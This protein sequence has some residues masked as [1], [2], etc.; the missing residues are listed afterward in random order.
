MP[1]RSLPHRQLRRSRKGSTYSCDRFTAAQ[2]A[3]KASAVRLTLHLLFTAAQAAQK[4]G[5]AI[6][7]M[8]KTFT[9]AQAAQKIIKKLSRGV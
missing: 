4:C 5:P 8:R 1:R 3:Q 6:S 9:A 2:A 7:H